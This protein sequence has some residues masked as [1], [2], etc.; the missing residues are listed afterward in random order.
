VELASTNFSPTSSEQFKSSVDKWAKE[1]KAHL[2][3]LNWLNQ[4]YADIKRDQKFDIV[5]PVIIQLEITRFKTS[6]P[7]TVIETGSSL[8]IPKKWANVEEYFASRNDPKLNQKETSTQASKYGAVMISTRAI[9]RVGPAR[10][11]WQMSD[12]AV[13]KVTWE[14]VKDVDGTSKNKIAE[15]VLKWVNG[16]WELAGEAP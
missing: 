13:I 3:V 2:G 9:D 12:R 8:E 6:Q 16:T 5:H 4:S 1:H 14:I 11:D 15:G 7:A 10:V